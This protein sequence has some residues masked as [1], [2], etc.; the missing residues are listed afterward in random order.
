MKRIILASSLLFSLTALSQTVN[1]TFLTNEIYRSIYGSGADPDDYPAAN[2]P[3]V[4]PDLQGDGTFEKKARLLIYLEFEDGIPVLR[5]DLCSY[6]AGSIPFR[7]SVVKVLLEA[8]KVPLNLSGSLPYN[9]VNESTL[10]YEHL[11]TAYNIG[12]LSNSS[13]FNPYNGIDADE[14][15]DYISFLE[16]SSSVD[17]PTQSELEDADNYFNPGIYNPLTLGLG[18]GIEQGVFSH[19]AKNS[20]IIPD[21]KMNLNFSHFYSNMMVEIPPD[22][23]AV[24]P[25]GRGWSHT[26]NSYIIRENNVGDGSDDY[27]YIVWPD[28]TIN[29]FNR[30]ED[31]YESIGVYD[32]FDEDSSSRIYITKKNQVR[33]KYQKLDSDRNLFYLTEIRDP[34]GNEINIDYESAEEEDTRRIESVEAPSGKKLE[35]RYLGNT[36]LVDR[37]EDPIGRKV[38][39]EYNGTTSNSILEYPILATFED[40]KNNLTTY[41]YNVNHQYE[42]YLLNRIDLPRGNE[43]TAQYDG[44][45]LESYKIN[46]DDPVTVDVNFDYDDNDFTS[47]VEIPTPSGGTLT[48]NYTFN[49]Y[50][51]V[52]QLD[53][54]T[55]E[56]TIDYPTSGVNLTL[57]DNTNAN[58]VDIEYEYDERGNVTKIDKE[59]GDVVEELEYDNDNNLTEYTDPNGN[60]TK[61]IYDG[62]E[63]LIEVQ[64]AFGNS[65]TYNYDSH[66]Q[67]ESVTNQEGITIS[68]TYENDGAVST[69]TAPADIES[70]F[71]YDGINR[72]LQRIDN[73]LVSSYG[74]D[75]ND[76]VISMVNSGGFT[77]SYNYDENDNLAS[78]INAHGVATS[79]SYDDQDR[80]ISETFGGLTKEYEYSDEGFLTEFKKPSG[81]DIDYEYDNDGRLKETGTITDIDYNSRNL[82]EDVENDVGTVSF[83]Y[84][85]LNRVEKVTTVHDF[86]VEYDYLDSGHIDEITYPTIG[87]VELEVNY[88]YDDKNRISQVILIRNV[89]EDGKVV[90]EY[91][92]LK[93]DRIRYLDYGNNVQKWFS[94]D[95]AG[96]FRFLRY[97][98]RDTDEV[99]YTG[100][101]LLD[102]RGNIVT[103]NEFFTPFSNSSI[104]PPPTGIASG[105]YN[106]N[107]HITSY[108]DTNYNVDDD[109]NI[110]GIGG[111]VSLEFDIDDRL[112]NY[113]NV[114]NTLNYKYNGFNQRVEATRNGVTTKYVRDVLSDNVLIEL[115]ENNSPLYYYIYSPSGTLITR[116]KPN[117]DL[118]YYHGDIRGSTVMVTDEDI[119]ITHQYRYDDF[120]VITEMEEPH[121][122]PNSFRY[123]GTYGVE[124]EF[125]DLYYMRARYYKASIGRF[126]SEDPIWHTNLYPYADNNP[127]SNI[128]PNGLSPVPILCK[129]QSSMALTDFLT[130]FAIL[131]LR[132]FKQSDKY[133]HA[134]ANFQATHRGK[135][136]ELTAIGLS[137]LREISDL[138]FDGNYDLEDQEAN[139]FGRT[140]AKY[141]HKD[142]FKEALSI[143]RPKYDIFPDHY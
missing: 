112:T 113:T 47:T 118:Q 41:Q 137:E 82:L 115:D 66:G 49:E 106:D 34:N 109:G 78:I 43:I 1:K 101:H 134:K 6:N 19:Y 55:D 130:N 74:Y 20:F 56:I 68:Y 93:D 136:G 8:Y 32:E 125:D 143:Y 72:L 14:L 13:S 61:F 126:L 67:L 139:R 129:Y 30:D 22:Y 128:D 52:T 99:I 81:T 116:M 71:S 95:A 28:G 111:D 33:Y 23:Y 11:L 40:A 124:H 103:S 9:D 24:K 31:E 140:Q 117:G 26:Y 63:N 4:Y 36:D 5:R 104:P 69:V 94:Y 27:Y 50:G 123:V 142:Q 133:F 105:S 12:M 100:S 17:P 121:D 79:F 38:F 18:K 45:R 54:D 44:G 42:K 97:E 102:A 75:N 48:Q 98:D 59:N 57:P 21:R 108:G 3:A 15:D 80:P 16:N 76:N 2:Y 29:V 135:C 88:S 119:N 25:L 96:R 89:G 86:D 62:D 114:D 51:L 10:Y 127:I 83:R 132:Q 131:Q 73:G 7:T 46:D 122:E 92:Y 120:G 90:A 141:Y 37:I 39:F 65:I 87:G 35:F 84:D 85:N 60:I 91:E 70:S 107:N 58:G 53:S 110:V 64:D 77:T 138:L